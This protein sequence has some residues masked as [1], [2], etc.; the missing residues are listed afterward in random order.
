MEVSVSK[1]KILETIDILRTWEG[2]TRA[3]KHDLQK[4]LGK[5]FHISRC[6]PLA[7]LFLGRMLEALRDSHRMGTVQ[8]S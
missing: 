4:L 3:T 6:S 7:H 1:Q 2:R 5:I 8:L